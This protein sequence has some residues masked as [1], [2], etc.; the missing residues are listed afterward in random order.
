[1]RNFF[2]EGYVINKLLNPKN[3]KIFK[4]EKLII[5]KKNLL[6]REGGLKF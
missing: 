4:D 6:E 3:Q 1:M 2:I 5:E